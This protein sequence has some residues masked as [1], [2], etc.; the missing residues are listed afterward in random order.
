MP[1]L[2]DDDLVQMYREGDADAFDVL[3]DRYHVPIYNFA[4]TMLGRADGAEDVLQEVFLAVARAARTYDPR[5]RFR[6]WLFR[7][8][9]NHCLN[10][11][12]S[13]RLRRRVIRESGLDLADAPS[14]GPSPADQAERDERLARLRGLITELPERQREA[15]VL[16][17]FEQ[18]SYQEVADVLGI[19][20]NTVK[21]LIH[22]ARAALAQRFE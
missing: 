11:L 21:T 9:R 2:G 16:Y 20:V 8:A 18:M 12:Q 6:A 4:R 22:R 19:P 7:L 15:I 5:G 13:E 17:A 3:F 14:G 10:R 1:S